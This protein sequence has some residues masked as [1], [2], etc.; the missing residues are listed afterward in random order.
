M[1]TS[2]IDW[3][4]GSSRSQRQTVSTVVSAGPPPSPE[5]A[6]D[7]AARIRERLRGNGVLLG[8]TGPHG[9][10]LKIRPPLVFGRRHADL[11]LQ[12]LRES[13]EWAESHP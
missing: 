4:P 10:V 3:L 11:L 9:N 7:A 12:T 13:L 1:V 2:A 6:P 8:T 5:P